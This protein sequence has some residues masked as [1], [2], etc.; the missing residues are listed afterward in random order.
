MMLL[1]LD[2]IPLENKTLKKHNSELAK[3]FYRE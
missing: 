3:F 1:I 2:L